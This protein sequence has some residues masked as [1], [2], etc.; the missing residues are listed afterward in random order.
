MEL[1]SSAR[2]FEAGELNCACG[3]EC[4]VSGSEGRVERI[5]RKRNE[6]SCCCYQAFIETIMIS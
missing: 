3:V 2:E 5:V 6:D 4:S 1:L